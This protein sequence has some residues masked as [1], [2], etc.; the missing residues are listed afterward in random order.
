M[1]FASIASSKEDRARLQTRKVKAASLS[2]FQ[3]H[4]ADQ[5]NVE[6]SKAKQ[7][8]ARQGKAGQGKV[9]DN[10]G[11]AILMHSG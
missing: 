1:C 9:S 2:N 3:S 11:E 4:L 5:P 6:Q 10:F 7:N 8:K